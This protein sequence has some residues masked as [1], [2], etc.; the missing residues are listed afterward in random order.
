MLRRLACL[1]WL[2]GQ[3]GQPFEA[4]LMPTAVVLG[5]VI[6][7]AV[8]FP[9]DRILDMMRTAVNVL[10]DSCAAVVIGKSEGEQGYYSSLRSQDSH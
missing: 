4:L 2:P 9:F 5:V 8:L 7:I 6:I 1:L 10:G 3:L